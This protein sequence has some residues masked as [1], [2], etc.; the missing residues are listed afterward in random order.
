MM[1]KS[2]LFC[3]FSAN[4]TGIKFYNAWRDLRS[5]MRVTFRREY[6]ENNVI[7]I[8][9]YD[10]KEL[11]HLERSVAAAI[12]PL[13]NSTTRYVIYACAKRKPCVNSQGSWLLLV[14]SP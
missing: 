14:C 4:V 3:S 11:G 2:K 12:A 9:T 1:E 10:T 6:D 8:L 13:H 7:V 5:M